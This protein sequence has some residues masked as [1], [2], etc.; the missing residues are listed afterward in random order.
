MKLLEHEA[1][2]LLE[3]RG[4]PIPSQGGIVRRG[5]ALAQALKRA[6]RGPWAL[7]AQVLAGGRGKAGGVKIAKSPA[8]ARSALASL[9]GKSLETHQTAGQGLKIREVLVESA[10]RIEREFYFSIVTD[11]R[12]GLPFAIASSQGG[13]EIETTAQERPEAILKISFDPDQGLADFKARRLGFFLGLK[14][15][16]AASFVAFAQAAARLYCELDLSLLEVNPLALTPRGLVALDAKVVFDDNALYRHPEYLKRPDPEASAAERRARKAG[17][18]YIGLDGTIGCLVNGAGLAMATMDTIALAGGRP[19]NFLDVGG[20]ADE[21]R[22]VEA[23]RI[24][25]GDPK[26]RG[27]L[28]NIFGGIVKCDMIAAGL[29]KAAARVKLKIPLVVRLEGT[30]VEEARKILSSSR[31]GLISADGLWDAAQKVV[32]A[33]DGAVRDGRGR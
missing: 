3:S 8:E 20:S 31:L 19:A 14:P 5:S 32:K 33:A 23:F 11:R 22:V 15:E 1:K 4:L 13:V 21:E 2:A 12:E 7:K 27:M 16:M 9:L 17:L 29:L 6:G 26:V 24:I 18:S 25:L 28:V 10:A 30:N